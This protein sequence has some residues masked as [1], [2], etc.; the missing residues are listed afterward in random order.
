VGKSD[1]PAVGEAITTGFKPTGKYR[2]H[3]K[4]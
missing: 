4:K 3:N 1:V 2:R